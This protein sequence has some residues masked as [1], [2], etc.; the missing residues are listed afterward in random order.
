VGFSDR[1]LFGLVLLEAAAIALT[2]AALGLGGAALLYGDGRF[3][4]GGFLQGFTVRGPTLVAGAALALLLAALSGLVP[5][6]RAA[7]LPVIQ[8][9][10]KVE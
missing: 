4:F 6:L 5:A 8:A 9:L 2:G 10:R 3:T 1:L 7:R